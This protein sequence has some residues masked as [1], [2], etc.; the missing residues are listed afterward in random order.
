MLPHQLTRL[1]QRAS[2]GLAQVGEHGTARNHSGD[3]FLAVSTANKLPSHGPDS[4]PFEQYKDLRAGMAQGVVETNMLEA[5]KNECVDAVFRAASE[6]VEEAILNS[7]A[8]NAGTG[9]GPHGR[10]TAAGDFVEALPGVRVRGLLE[11]YLI[12]V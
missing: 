6:A 8:A 11:R 9:P 3:I 7:L 1:A 5:T 2:I 12:V 4:S 10:K